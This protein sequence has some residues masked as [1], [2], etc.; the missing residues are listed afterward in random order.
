MR[1]KFKQLT[2]LLLAA[3]LVATSAS[4][5][6][7]SATTVA[8]AASVTSLSASPSRVS[9]HDPSILEAVDGTY[10]AFGSHLDAA[11][12]KDLVNWTTFTNG[13]TAKN[14]AIFGD[15]STNL[16]KAFKWAGEDDVDCKGTFA[17][18][19]PDVFYNKDYVNGDGT[20]GAYM[21]YFCTS[22]TAIRSV[23]AYAVSQKPD[24][25]Y[26][27]VDT[28]IYSGFTKG[29]QTDIGSDINTKYTETNIGE[30][31]EN[32]TLKDGVNSNWF[33]GTAYNASYAPNAIDPTIF[34]D[35]NGKLWMTY[36]SWSGGIFIL[37]IDPETGAAIYPGKNSTTEDGL[38]VDE[39]F[40]TRI[41][42][43]YR[44]SG[45]GPYILYDKESDY[46]YLYVTYEFLNSVSGYNMRL[47]RS[48]N[49]DGPYLD[50]AGNNAAFAKNINDSEHNSIGIKVM[51]NYKFSSFERGY[52]SPGHNSVFIDSDGQR[53]LLY[54]TRFEDSGEYHQL[55]VHQQ[56]INKEGWPVTAVFENKGD[57]ISN[58][59][60]TTDDIAG[61]YEFINHGIQSDKNN[62]KKP[63][64]I[65]LNAD[66]TISGDINGTWKA[67]DGS[68]Y[69]E[70][71]IDGITYSG[72]FFAQHDE[73]AA[74]NKVMTFT[75]IG[76]DNKTIWGVKKELFKVS[77]KEVTD[78][79]IDELVNSDVVPAKTLSDIAL[80]S[81]TSNGA[82]VTWTSGNKSVISDD[83][84][85]TRL[86]DDAEAPLTA[87]VT[88]GTSTQTKVFTTIIPAAI[89]LPDYAYDF[90]TVDGTEVADTGKSG[91][92]AKLNGNASVSKEP[93][94]GNVLTVK[95]STDEQGIN[96]LSLPSAMFKNVNTAG[97]TLSMWVK[98]GSDSDDPALFEAKS[99]S[100]YDKLPMTSIHAG[101]YADYISHE[102]TLTGSLGLAPDKNEWAHIVYTVSPEG[103]KVYVNGDIRSDN[104]NAATKPLKAGLAN[105][106]ISQID[107]IRIGSGMMSASYDIPE[108]SFDDIEFYSIA[109][110][111]ATIS[112]KYQ[113]VKDSH[114]T[115]KLSSTK[116]TIYAGGDK[117]QTSQLSIDGN[118]SSGYS[119]AYS[120][121]DES[122]AS[123]NEAGTV[124]A[125]KAGT[126]TITA[127]VTT[128]GETLTFT[129][130]ITVKKAYLKFSKKKTS[131]K[132][133]K[134]ATFKV[135]G[136]GLKAD[137]IKWS[138]SKP[139]VLAVKS[140]GKVTAKKKG[141]AK[142]TA[143]Y[144]GFK[145]SVKVKVKK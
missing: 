37:G 33:S 16:S 114:P 136:Y 112:S 20:K 21:M 66:G 5:I 11:K 83:G 14:N 95:N 101:A 1:K 138:S 80:P 36:G 19:A 125:N 44:K 54:H 116:G 32:G 93:L 71:V 46:Y 65:K 113:E 41:A 90:E 135:K 104:T 141:T 77:D 61:E 48:K 145:V 27:F 105:E 52:K 9:V 45:E 74:C 38:V 127:T 84:K 70:A 123:V 4:A 79:A 144:N 42:G 96:Y 60:Y 140:N 86:S 134:S 49:P 40:G 7:P 82:K 28:L 122:A 3:T 131:L 108:A 92:A 59:G 119:V 67:E 139:A 68:Y 30:L 15:L 13:Y 85:I 137:K 81:G 142:I 53:Y 97:F 117:A 51:G 39:Y 115:L 43:G 129:K 29:K 6:P 106:I 35:K 107:D 111:A 87:T 55:R 133:K 26:T 98:S 34:Y 103:I 8:D 73:T 12:S 50:A 124:T 132:V 17:V 10:Y 89:I 58:A 88:Y 130:K 56:F 31:I 57:A 118:V 94:A 62:V 121:S 91:Q 64:N 2:S 72:I 120:S 69:M 110:D 24:G 126:T 23:I 100:A 99:S 25:P 47:F 22:S 63:Q 102:A 128:N 76:T 109:L 18:W 143:K 78:R 75:A